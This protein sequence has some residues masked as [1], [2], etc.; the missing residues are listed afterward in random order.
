MQLSLRCLWTL[1]AL[2]ELAVYDI[3]CALSGF[4]GVQRLMRHTRSRRREA[5]LEPTIRAAV[6]S[7]S[8]LYWK[9]VKC[10]QRAVALGRLLRGYC[11]LDTQVVIGYRA[12]P[13]IGHAWV[14]IQRRAGQDSQVCPEE[15]LQVLMR[16]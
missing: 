5:E 10:L 12:L 7:A 16:L 15:H 8:I 6:L 11:A 2:R 1:R 9:P 13:F 4:R 14:E 3:V